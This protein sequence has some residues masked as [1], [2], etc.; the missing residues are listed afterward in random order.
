MGYI[1]TNE[2]EH[3]DFKEAQIAELRLQNGAFYAVLDNVKI[4]PENSKNRDIRKMRTNNLTFRI[5]DC[6]IEAFVEEGYKTYN[7]DGVLQQQVADRPI[8]ESEYKSAFE[9]LVECTIYSLE[10]EGDC[11]IFSIDTE[12]HT[13]LLKIS[14][15]EDREEWE[16]FFSLDSM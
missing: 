2:W 10:K 6:S 16:K 1:T 7:A 11:Y 8:P 15:T 9:S 3:F 5:A 13:F 4:L 14:G 12:D